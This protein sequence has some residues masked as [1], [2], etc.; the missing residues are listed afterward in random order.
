MQERR[1]EPRY[2][3]A[4]LVKVRVQAEGGPPEEVDATLEDISGS[5][6]CVQLEAAIDLG[7]DVEIVCSRCRLRGKVR[8][9]RFS[10]LGYDVG[11]EFEQRGAW[12]RRQFEPEHLVDFGPAMQDWIESWAERGGAACNRPSHIL[13]DGRK[14]KSHARCM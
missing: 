4:D 2:M 13:A 14:N 8:H 12:D 3:C 5:G 9:C 7:A 6:A 10:E 11:V 1:S